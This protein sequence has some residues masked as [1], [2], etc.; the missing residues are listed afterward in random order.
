MKNLGN[1]ST[2]NKLGFGTLIF[3]LILILSYCKPKTSEQLTNP[4]EFTTPLG[5]VYSLSEPSEKLL[6]QFEEAKTAYEKE[7]DNP[8]LLIWYGRRKAYLGHYQEAIDIYTEGIKKFPED[9]RIYRHRGHRYI[10]IREFD[11]AINDLSKAS[12]LIEGKPNEIEPDG[13]PNAQNIPVSTLH[14]NIWYHLGLAYYLK[15]DFENAHKAYLKCRESGSKDDNLV[16]STHWLYMIQRR[17]GNKLAADSLLQPITPELKI[18]ENMSYHKL[19]LFYQGLLSEE[20]LLPKGESSSASD[21]VAYG[22]ANWYLVEGQDKKGL[23]LMRQIVEGPNWSS[24]GY[25]AAE[26]DMLDKLEDA[27]ITFE[28]KQ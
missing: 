11:K 18:I 19:C 8:D 14:G 23:E 26:S 28:N 13:M 27:T 10:S 15:Q 16:S 17:L 6:Q 12:E 25:I 9:A 24:F 3:G 2:V 21:A 4:K 20:E 7:P 1:P 22:L 5:K